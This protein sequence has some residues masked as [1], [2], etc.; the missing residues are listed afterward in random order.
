MSQ[1]NWPHTNSRASTSELY[2]PTREYTVYDYA[3]LEAIRP[4]SPS[5]A[6][7]TTGT[8]QE[9][10]HDRTPPYPDITVS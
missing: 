3:Q 8:E 5:A 1:A 10:Q 9:C 4:D 6:P 2:S 7:D